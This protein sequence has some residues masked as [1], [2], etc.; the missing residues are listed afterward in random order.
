MPTNHG[1]IEFLKFPDPQYPGDKTKRIKKWLRDSWARR[2]IVDL[3]D[4]FTSKAYVP[5]GGWTWGQSF[6]SSASAVYC[7]RIHNTIQVTFAAKANTAI[8]TAT[9]RNIVTNLPG[10]M[11]RV[12][13]QAFVVTFNNGVPSTITPV[14]CAIRP[15][16]TAT[17]SNQ[18]L[19]VDG[20][21][22]PTAIPVGGTIY[23]TI[24]YISNNWS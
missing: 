15:E 11:T 14:M 2:K 6:D 24:V 21:T 4:K 5:T 9:S 16:E 18:I 3:F 17:N 7:R 22:N 20:A 10:A 13:S 1:S 12:Y 23:G 8:T 19:K